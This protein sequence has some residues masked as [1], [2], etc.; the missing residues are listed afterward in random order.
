MA[1]VGR[2]DTVVA[3]EQKGDFIRSI[4][5]ELRSPLHGILASAEFLGETKCDG[6]QKSLVDTVD[7]CGRAL[8]DTINHVLDFS[9]INSFEK[10]LQNIRKPRRGSS[11]SRFRAASSRSEGFAL[12]NIYAETNVAAVCEEVVEGVF[13]G[14]VR[15]TLH[16]GDSIMR[17]TI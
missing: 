11:G 14:Q 6:F 5:H 13:A 2:L 12:L 4:S 16:Q 8:L 3:N 9:K 17:L 15:Y 10:D 7:S 1:E